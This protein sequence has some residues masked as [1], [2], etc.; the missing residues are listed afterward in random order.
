MLKDILTNVLSDLMVLCI[1]WVFNQ[2]FK[3]P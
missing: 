1:V 3:H 2:T